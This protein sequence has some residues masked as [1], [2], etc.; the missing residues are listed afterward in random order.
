MSINFDEVKRRACQIQHQ[1]RQREGEIPVGEALAE[2]RQKL[3]PIADQISSDLRRETSGS[4][5]KDAWWSRVWAEAFSGLGTRALVPLAVILLLAGFLPGFFMGR[6]TPVSESG[7][8]SGQPNEYGVPTLENLLTPPANDV[9]ALEAASRV[10]G[11]YLSVHPND[12]WFRVRLIQIE[13][14]RERLLTDPQ[15]RAKLAAAVE[16]L[17]KQLPQHLNIDLN[18]LPYEGK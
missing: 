3:V 1:D 4:G 5:K 14:A 2:L 6:E 10:L 12:Q 8:R 11:Q 9:P 7:V 18:Q 17:R 15:E 16:G 13:L